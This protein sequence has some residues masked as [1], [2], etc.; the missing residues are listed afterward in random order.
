[1]ANDKK[2]FPVNLILRAFDKVTAPLGKIAGSLKLFNDRVKEMTQPTRELTK[3]WSR[4][5]DVTGAKRVGHAF[6]QMRGAV[7]NLAS[8]IGS[9]TLQLGAAAVAGVF[10]VNKMTDE[11]D[12]LAKIADRTGFTIQA[13]AEFQFVA[14]RAGISAE[15]FGNAMQFFNKQLGMAHAH[16]GAMYAFLGKVTPRLLHQALA[17]RDNEKALM[18]LLTAMTKMKSHSA[19]AAFG[20]IVFGKAAGQKMANLIEHGMLEVKQ[21]REEFRRLVGDQTQFARLSEEWNDM[22]GDFT[23]VIT[24][25]SRALLVALLPAL[26]DGLVQLK[27]FLLTHREMIANFAKMA[28]AKIPKTINDIVGAYSVMLTIVGKVSDAVGGYKN[29]LIILAG[30]RLWPLVAAMWALGK[31][32]WAMSMALGATPF[33]WFLVGLAALVALG[34]L[35]ADTWDWWGPYWEK[36]AGFVGGAIDAVVQWVSKMGPRLGRALGDALTWAFDFAKSFIPD[37]FKYLMQ[38]SFDL[39][40]QLGSSISGLMQPGGAGAPMLPGAAGFTPSFSPAALRQQIDVNFVNA[41]RGTRAEAQPTKFGTVN[42][43]MG[44]ALQDALP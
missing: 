31:A 38:G 19:Q 13:F 21:L 33:G 24:G 35:L 7:S 17:V 29:L 15:E 42:L 23:L 6:G 26:T 44:Y 1:M 20:A 41:P 8:Q 39:G 25:A 18:L 27:E 10:F 32:T 30:I 40:Q 43:S 12:R 2:D 28:A 4:F 34:L 14:Q 5:L 36:F 11:G 37:W 16:T 3:Q 22:W 9:L